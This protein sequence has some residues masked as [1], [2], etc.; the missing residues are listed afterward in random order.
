MKNFTKLFKRKKQISRIG[1]IFTFFL[2]LT[3]CYFLKVV[4]QPKVANPNSSFEATVVVSGK[5]Y[6]DEPNPI[7]LSNRE[8][9]AY[10]GILIP[11]GWTVDDP[12]VFHKKATPEETLDDY[13][14]GERGKDEEGILM[15]DQTQTDY[16]ETMSSGKYAAPEGYHWWG[17][18]TEFKVDWM[19]LDTAYYKV[20]ILT[21]EKLGEFN[22]RYV[23]WDAIQIVSDEKDSGFLP[24]TISSPTGIPTGINDVLE[25]SL[26]TYPNPVKDV[27]NVDVNN[28]SDKTSVEILNSNGVTLEKREIFSEHNQFDLS[29]YPN[30]TY[31]VVIKQNGEKVVRKVLL[32]K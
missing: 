7:N 10:I 24:I 18:A 25:S 22:L 2:F 29:G 5:Y 27:L 31:F 21:D 13:E 8:K 12:I 28:I 23:V 1:I 17:G 14:E 16:L 26:N 4:Y 11:D 6:Q 15:F 20:N 32:Q 9:T 30:G 3:G 19:D